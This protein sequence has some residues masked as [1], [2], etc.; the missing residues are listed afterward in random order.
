MA[1]TILPAYR[2]PSDVG[3]PQ[4]TAWNMNGTLLLEDGGTSNY[5]GNFGVGGPACN[6][7]RPDLNRYC[8]G[9]FGQNSSV[10]MS[11]LKDGS[12]N[13]IGVA[14]RRMGRICRGWN[15]NPS[16]ATQTPSKYAVRSFCTWWAGTITASGGNITQ[17]TPPPSDPGQAIH[18]VFTTTIGSPTKS[19]YPGAVVKLNAEQVPDN[20]NSWGAT[21]P[22]L[23]V[24]QDDS[25]I[26]VSSYHTGGAHIGLMDG[27]VRFVSEGINEKTYVDLSRRSDGATL[28]PF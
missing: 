27:T 9:V 11:D 12:S 7:H 20:G 6:S 25:P 23:P 26:G 17:N 14:E 4:A 3:P 1:Q 8:Q 2:C 28:A 10:R 22:L 18:I 5:P 19:G 21:A 24:L 16:S 13:V 15:D